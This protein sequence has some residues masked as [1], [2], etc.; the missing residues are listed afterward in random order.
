MTTLPD[1][2]LVEL[3]WLV[4]AFPYDPVGAALAPQY[5]SNF[6]Y[7]TAAADSPA[8]QAYD[9]ALI[10]P[11]TVA[12]H[13]FISGKISGRS[14]ASQCTAVVSNPA[15][16][17][18]EAQKMAGN[19][20]GRYDAWKGY[21]WSGRRVRV[22]VGVKDAAYSTFI[23][24]VDG[25]ATS[26]TIDRDQITIN[27]ASSLQALNK[28]MQT[29]FYDG[30]GGI[31]GTADLK[32]KPH[33]TALGICRQV[34]GVLIDSAN[35]IYH[36]NHGATTAIPAAWDG[37]ASVTKDANDY[38]DYAALVA[39]TIGAGKYTTCLALGLA[40]FNTKPTGAATFDVQGQSLKDAPNI[41]KY[42]ISTY[43]GLSSGQYDGTAFTAATALQGADCGR[44]YGT[45]PV[46]ILDVLDFILGGIGFWYTASLTG[47]V[48]LG[49]LD[50]PT[51]TGPTDGNCALA[52]TIDD[53]VD[54]GLTLTT[55]LEPPTQIQLEYQRFHLTQT[56]GVSTSIT[57]AQQLA[58]AQEWRIVTANTAG[59]VATEYPQAVP[60]VVE[61]PF[62]A[63]ADAQ[64][65]ATR[66]ATL[67]GKAI[68]IYDWKTFTNPF[69]VVLGSQAWGS[70]PRYQLSAGQAF[71]AIGSDASAKDQQVTVQMLGV[72][73]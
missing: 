26:L 70:H 59:T 20:Y 3:Q 71:I 64:T 42:V 33:P 4:E 31:G 48:T 69:G 37:G 56:T 25:Y 58:I 14:D 32:G 47:V 27:F 7:I 18:T 34:P 57:A 15:D 43:G 19:A 30:T 65:E 6:D 21:R 36:L 2:A 11:L 67:L 38:A 12:N 22:L 5:L 35:L 46:L 63:S 50:L 53:T 49:R 17:G 45:D 40:R 54:S 68:D 52:L 41:A 23:P 51:I 13:L 9:G 72:A 29:N 73:A 39:A 55:T 61:T 10:E 1:G 66:L 28:P 60:L 62:D 8:S 16:Q 44:W 24:V